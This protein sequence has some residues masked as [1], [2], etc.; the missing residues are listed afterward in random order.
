MTNKPHD[1]DEAIRDRIQLEVTFDSMSSSARPTIWKNM[2]DRV[3]GKDAREGLWT[4]VLLDALSELE[5]SGREIK[6]LL[7][8]AT[9]H[10][11]GEEVPMNPE[12][13]VNVI[14]VKSKGPVK[15]LERIVGANESVY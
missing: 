7:R 4:P 14:R 10:A 11:N 2:L 1:F 6:N 8:L 15:G 12:H 5:V 9:C 3:P 13:L